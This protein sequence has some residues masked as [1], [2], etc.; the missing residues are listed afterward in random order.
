MILLIQQNHYADPGGNGPH[1]HSEDP[2]R[3]GSDRPPDFGSANPAGIPLAIG[4]NSGQVLRV[5]RRQGDAFVMRRRPK[6]SL[7]YGRRR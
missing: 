2:Y 7:L 1:S 3:I 5:R 4:R 6:L